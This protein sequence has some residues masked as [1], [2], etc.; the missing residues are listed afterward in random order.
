MK[1]IKN[2]ESNKPIFEWLW[3]FV[4]S[5]QQCN[6]A[7]NLAGKCACKLNVKVA[8]VRKLKKPPWCIFKHG[9]DMVCMWVH[10]I[11]MQMKPD[12]DQ[13]SIC[14]YKIHFHLSSPFLYC[15]LKHTHTHTLWFSFLF[16][17]VCL[18]ITARFLLR[19]YVCI[20]RALSLSLLL[21][22]ITI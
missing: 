9:V 13:E 6:L 12:D 11:R 17:C 5:Q 20:A 19:M 14:Y 2:S 16:I 21:K 7:R 18:R 3:L 1:K 4:N 10:V 8:N 15:T 22:I